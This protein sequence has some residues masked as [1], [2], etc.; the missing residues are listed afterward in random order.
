MLPIEVLRAKAQQY[1]TEGFIHEDIA[2][3]VIH[4]IEGERNSAMLLNDGDEEETPLTTKMGPRELKAE[5]EK[6]EA[7]MRGDGSAVSDQWRVYT[8]II[9]KI[10]R[11]DYLRLR[12]QAYLLRL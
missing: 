12:V 4:V 3:R 7:L 6:R 11:G 5:L 8:H 1:V 10:Q 2:H 9:S